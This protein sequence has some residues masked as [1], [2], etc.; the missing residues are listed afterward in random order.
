MKNIGEDVN[1]DIFVSF[2]QLF[3]ELASGPLSNTQFII[4]DKEYIEPDDHEGINIFERFMT[5]EHPEN[6]P[7]IS[8][9]RGP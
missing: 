5:P 7:L 2:Y 3:Y 1:R 9:Y 4:I 8:Y 6:P